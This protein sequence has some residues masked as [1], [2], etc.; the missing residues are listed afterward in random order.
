MADISLG[1]KSDV[2]TVE[3]CVRL[4]AIKSSGLLVWE[5]LEKYIIVVLNYDS[6][7]L[8]SGP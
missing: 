8:F 3:I 1:H 5:I 7:V 6:D 2:S 4:Q